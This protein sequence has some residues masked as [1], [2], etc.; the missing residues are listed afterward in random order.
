MAIGWLPPSRPLFSVRPL[1]SRA[2][3]TFAGVEQRQRGRH[4]PSL[5]PYYS[6]VVALLLL[7]GRAGGGG[8]RTDVFVSPSRCDMLDVGLDRKES[9]CG[10]EAERPSVCSLREAESEGGRGEGVGSVMYIKKRDHHHASRSGKCHFFL[11]LASSRILPYFRLYCRHIALETP[12]SSWSLRKKRKPAVAGGDGKRFRNHRH[13]RPPARSHH[14]ILAMKL[15]SGIS[16]AAVATTW[17]AV[18]CQAMPSPSSSSSSPSSHNAGV[19]AA[20]LLGRRSL[21]TIMQQVPRC[22]VS[23]QPSTLRHSHPRCSRGL[24]T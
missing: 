21:S 17:L 15:S 7:A 2:S 24:L 16:L 6:C 23:Y 22:A 19:D 9:K 4:W 3:L 14:H 8:S 5:A 12:I 13:R 20:A 10:A 1:P 18:V 11:F